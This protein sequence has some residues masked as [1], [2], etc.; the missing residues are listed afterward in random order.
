VHWQVD[1]AVTI[2]A[3]MKVDGDIDATGAISLGAKSHLSGCARSVGA[4]S[5][6]AG[7]T[8]GC[9]SFLTVSDLPPSKSSSS[10]VSEGTVWAIGITALVVIVAL[11]L[12]L[13]T[14]YWKTRE[15]ASIVFHSEKSSSPSSLTTKNIV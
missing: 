2:A 7:A 10:G 4:L 9:A 11:I 5:L 15:Q 13:S 1:G 3:G 8:C 6:G 12:I 14:V